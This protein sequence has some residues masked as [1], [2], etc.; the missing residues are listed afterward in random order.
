[1]VIGSLNHNVTEHMIVSC[2]ILLI[3]FAWFLYNRVQVLAGGLESGKNN[4]VAA[5]LSPENIVAQ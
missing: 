5:L 1:M 2:G 3:V 4:T